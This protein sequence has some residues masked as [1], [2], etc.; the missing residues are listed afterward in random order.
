MSRWPYVF[1]AAAVTYI[2]VG[3]IWGIYMSIT[4]DFATAPG[5]AHLN[6]LGWVSL[7]L[8][9][10]FYALLGRDTPRWLIAGNFLLNNIGVVCMAGGLALGLSQTVPIEQ[11][12]PLIAVGAFATL[13]GF[14]AF[15]GAVIIGLRNAVP[16]DRR[17]RTRLAAA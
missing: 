11:L 5:H 12:A 4:H 10:G 17:Q 3:V 1:F 13:L 14:A 7:S 8:M 9:G 16:A 6:L 2:L 15:A